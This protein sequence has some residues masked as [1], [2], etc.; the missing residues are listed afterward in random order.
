M[1]G[2]QLTALQV[3]EQRNYFSSATRVEDHVWM[4]NWR[5]MKLPYCSIYVIAPIDGWPC[6]IGV[7]TF[8]LKRVMGIQ[9][10]VW[11]QLEVKF[12]AFTSST[13]VARDLERRCHQSLSD[14]SKWLHGEWFDLRPEAAAD[15][16][17]FE[18]ELAGIE[19]HEKLPSEGDIYDHV[20]AFFESRYVDPAGMIAAI[21]RRHEFNSDPER[22]AFYNP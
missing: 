20:R 10:S 2:R 15:L 12:C 6:K 4:A 5:D 9:T 3:A 1:R 21:E 18:A 8:P 16:V 11:K 14:Q 22:L 7:S 13:Q 19:I 17:R